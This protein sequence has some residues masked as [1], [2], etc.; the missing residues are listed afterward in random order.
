MT[1]PISHGDLEDIIAARIAA[2]SATAYDQ[3][4][5]GTSAF[6]RVGFT[7]SAGQDGHALDHLAFDVVCEGETNPGVKRFRSGEVFDVR[8]RLVIQFTYRLRHRRDHIGDR[9]L[10]YAAGADVLKQMA[11][12]HEK[13]EVAYVNL[14]RTYREGLLLTELKFD[15]LHQLQL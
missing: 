13:F 6:K 14:D 10:A 8:T 2:I 9:K 7:E 11:I 12:R 3:G 5:P 15:V 1:V 4:R